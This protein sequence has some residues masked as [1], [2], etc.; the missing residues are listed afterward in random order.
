MLA[1]PM[2]PKTL[3]L[4]YVSYSLLICGTRFSVHCLRRTFNAETVKKGLCGC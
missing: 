2:F 1:E 3:L 4:P